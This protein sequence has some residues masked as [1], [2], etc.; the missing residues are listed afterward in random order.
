MYLEY[1]IGEAEL[2]I[3]ITQYE[4]TKDPIVIAL[5]SKA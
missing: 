4:L 5:V 1:G 3:A 2:N